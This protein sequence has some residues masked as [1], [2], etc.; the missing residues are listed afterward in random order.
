MVRVTYSAS[1]PLA[2]FG[3]ETR[4]L[5]P[6]K[7]RRGLNVCSNCFL[8]SAAVSVVAGGKSGDRSELHRGLCSMKSKAGLRTALVD[9]TIGRMV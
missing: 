4:L 7:T 3:T 9:H 5:S 2:P 6:S 1:A 8:S